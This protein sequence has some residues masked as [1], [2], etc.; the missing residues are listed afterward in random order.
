M[1][2][3]LIEIKPNSA[4]FEITGISSSQANALRRTLINDIPKLAIDKIM[5]HHGQ[6]RD[7][8]GNVYDSSLPLF[9]EVV[10]HRIGLLPLKTDLMS[11]ASL[12]YL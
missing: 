6:I 11:S 9:D 10:A 4:L 3:K 12:W 1:A 2:L 8:D 7:M 5:F